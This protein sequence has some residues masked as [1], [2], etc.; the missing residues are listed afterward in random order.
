MMQRS[1][2][3]AAISQ[4]VQLSDSGLDDFREP[5]HFLR[6]VTGRAEGVANLVRRE[7]GQ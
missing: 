5:V 2:E 7:L 3:I 4:F 1:E 6:R